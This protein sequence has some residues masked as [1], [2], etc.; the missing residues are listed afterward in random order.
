M[1][2]SRLSRT[3]GRG[4]TR[5]NDRHVGPASP[6]RVAAAAPLS[7]LAA[8]TGRERL[9]VDSRR[10]AA[11]GGRGVRGAHVVDLGL[12]RQQRREH[13]R[14][15]A[16]P[17]SGLP[18]TTV[19][20]RVSRSV[21]CSAT[22]ARTS[23]QPGG[24]PTR[25]PTSARRALRAQRRVARGRR[26][27]D[28]RQALRPACAPW[29][30]TTPFAVDQQDDEPRRC[31]AARH[32]LVHDDLHRRAASCRA[33]RRCA[34][35]P[36]RRDPRG[37]RGGV[38]PGQRRARRDVGRGEHLGRRRPATSRCTSHRARRRTGGPEQTQRG[39]T[40]QRPA[41]APSTTS[42][43]Q[44][45]TSAGP[46]EPAGAPAARDVG[47]QRSRPRSPG[48]RARAREQGE[49]LGADHRDVA[50]PEGEHDVARA[51]RGRPAGRPPP[52]RTARRRTCAGGSGT[53][54]ATQRA[55]HAGHRVLARGVD[56]HHDDLVGQPERRAELGR[57]TSGCGCRGAAGRR[58]R[59][60]PARR[61]R[62]RRRGRPR[63]SVGWWA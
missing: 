13:R 10:A 41:P 49:H 52:T 31:T 16:S 23:T 56:V 4:R 35:R 32:P 63:S 7:T 46:R 29:S 62:G 8:R 45:R 37:D 22:A 5:F 50:R 11:T 55:G 42:S 15:C 27:A 26:R 6:R 14:P 57:R 3:V 19:R 59:P 21:T 58:R 48:P 53:A 60:G 33:P 61:R 47:R 36:G 38:H 9:T 25:A 1:S 28:Q 43:Q 54:A 30:N 12:A 39:G 51:A 44:P 40:G 2:T 17:R 18:H 20:P 34:R 24:A